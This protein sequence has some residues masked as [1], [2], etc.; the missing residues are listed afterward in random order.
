MAPEP[1]RTVVLRSFIFKNVLLALV[2]V[3]MGSMTCLRFLHAISH[4]LALS[5]GLALTGTAEYALMCFSTHYVLTCGVV[6]VGT[7]EN[8]DMWFSTHWPCEVHCHVV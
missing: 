8:T 2:T 1:L 3:M 4:S 5:S 6:L 7:V